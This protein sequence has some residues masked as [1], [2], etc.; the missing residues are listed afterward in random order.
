MLYF[1][2]QYGRF[3]CQHNGQNVFSIDWIL[4]DNIIVG[5]TPEQW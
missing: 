5:Y 2:Y 1:S 4:C 3:L